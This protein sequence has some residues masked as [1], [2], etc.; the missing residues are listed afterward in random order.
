M[1]M[2]A[3]HHTVSH[4]WDEVQLLAKEHKLVNIYADKIEGIGQE[5]AR[6]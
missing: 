3:F 4:I 6:N 5:A 2:K 1:K